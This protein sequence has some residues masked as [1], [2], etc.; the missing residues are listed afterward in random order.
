[1]DNLLYKENLE[2][3]CKEKL[4]KDIKKFI[5]CLSKKQLDYLRNKS[6]GNVIILGELEHIPSS[7]QIPVDITYD[8]NK[9]LIKD[10]I[11]STEDRKFFTFEMIKLRWNKTNNEVEHNLV[12]YLIEPR[13]IYNDDRPL[14]EKSNALLDC[15]I[16]FEEYIYAVEKKENIA[17]KFIESIS[18]SNNIIH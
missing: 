9:Y 10:I 4:E 7:A 5:D 3:K 1:M 15:C 18:F 11:E 16:F 13:F 6:N 14:D 2:K 17:P 12:K 8:I